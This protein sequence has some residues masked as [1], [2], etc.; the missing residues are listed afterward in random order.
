M[1]KENP[2]VVYSIHD[3]VHEQKNQ[4]KVI[5][6]IWLNAHSGFHFNEEV[7]K[8]AKDAISSSVILSSIRPTSSDI[9]AYIKML[10]WKSS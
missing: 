3:S 5:K 10:L 2:L 9:K 1:T 4:G 8:T 6:I 7:D